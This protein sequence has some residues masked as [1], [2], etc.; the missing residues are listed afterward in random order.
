MWRIIT[1]F[2][3]VMT[4]LM[5]DAETFS[6]RFN[7]TTLTKAIR[8]IMEDHPELDINFIYNELENYRTSEIVNADNAYDALRQTIG[9]NPVT[10]TKARNTY[11]VEA[12]Q[13]GRYIYTGKIIGSDNEPVVAATI[14]LLAPK[15]STVLTYGIS[16]TEG[17]FSIPCDR[18]GVLGK[19]TCL[20]YK[21]KIESFNK[22]SLGTILMEEQAI[23][24]G[25]VTVEA[26]NAQLYSDK[27]IY[28][29]SETQ[30]KASISGSDLLNRMAIPQLGVIS[31]NSIV[32][33]GGKPVAVFIDYLPATEKDLQ[34][35]RVSDVKRVE[36]LEY[37]SDPR[38]QGSAYV[39]NFIMQQYEYGGYAKFYGTGSL[40][41]GHTEQG[42]ANV[43][44]QYKRMTY[45]LMGS[46]YDNGINHSGE[47]M[48]ETFRLPQEDGSLKQFIRKS[49]TTGSQQ[50]R[51]NY[52][53]IFRATYN[54]DKVQASSLINTNLDR[55]PTTVQNG[56][57]SY[58]P[59]IAPNSEYN[60]SSSKFS[61]FISYDGYYFF[62]LP[63][64]NSFIFNP[65]Y[66]LSHTEQ[67]SS[68]LEEGYSS[69]RNSATDNTNKLSADIKLKHDFGKF[70]SLLAYAKGSYQYN[71]TLYSGTA[72][73]LDRTKAT[74]LGTGVNYEFSFN[75]LRSH[76]G[77]GWDWDKL[78]FGQETDRRNAPS[79]DVSLH[80]MPDRK[81]SV[82]VIFQMES[83]LPS[84]NFKSDQII[85]ASPF[86]KY[87]GN[88]NLTTAKSYDFDFNYTWVPNNNY[89][90]SAYGWGWIINDRYAY[91]YEPDGQG[92]I[93][94]IKQPMGAYAQGIYGIKGSARL[95]DRSVVLT[96][97]LSQ[98]FNHNGRPYNVNHFHLYYTLQMFYY[99]KNWNFGITYVSPIG[100][101]D[102]M[103]NGIW[104]RDKDNYYLNVGWSDSNW[105]FSAMIRNIAR[106]NWKSSQRI[107]NS[108][109]YSTDETLI[110]GSYHATIKFTVT[111]T[112]GFGKKV[113]RDNEPQASGS[114]SSGI[115]K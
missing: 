20:G 23:S 104:Q 1:I 48:K 101:W 36:Y 41:N 84:P 57:V 115:L 90:L 43:R 107:M 75:N 113:K 58:S 77:F 71:R 85:T 46:A 66:S 5:S 12:L 37:P 24:L 42:I 6:Y 4:F 33:N 39:V 92:V 114:A 69:I 78:R 15:D 100:T 61:K 94:T 29:P 89:S 3:A 55:Q 91:D 10:V 83:W 62:N 25:T 14:M 38:L 26:D 34:A 35:M 59:E 30:K 63:K 32:T 52:Y 53:L 105:R 45:D 56:F 18:K 74:R 72:D 95:L 80:Y 76:I 22:F 93:R 67:N 28:R 111:Y 109:F 103:M 102:G 60:S 97:N 96:G 54:S 99:L 70:G 106:W 64:S 73:A 40:L 7:S 27:S 51:G 108:E 86:L 16:D 9:L 21:P 8:E 65:K 79:F 44:M 19:L 112:F 11:Y 88:P 13:H 17:Q 87:T 2:A 68:Y 98:L 31:G 47:E 110:N 81:H 49:E 82:S 50:E